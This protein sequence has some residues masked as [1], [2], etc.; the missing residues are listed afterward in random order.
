MIKIIF[1]LA[2]LSS[3]LFCASSAQRPQTFADEVDAAFEEFLTEA[4]I[5]TETDLE[6]SFI[7]GEYNFVLSENNEGETEVSIHTV[8]ASEATNLCGALTELI[9]KLGEAIQ[10]SASE[11]ETEIDQLNSAEEDTTE[12]ETKTEQDNNVTAAEIRQFGSEL[13]A[14]ASQISAAVVQSYNR[15]AAAHDTVYFNNLANQLSNAL[16]TLEVHSTDNHDAVLKVLAGIQ[17]IEDQILQQ[18]PETATATETETN[19]VISSEAIDNIKSV[20]SHNIT[21]VAGIIA[22]NSTNTTNP[23]V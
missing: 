2:L 20:S 21:E 8:P 12:T 4:V 1:V 23:S 7:L 3:T 16:N 9:E 11:I 14:N 17:S 6:S 15:A 10:D 22:A 19:L 13:Q 5:F 18:G